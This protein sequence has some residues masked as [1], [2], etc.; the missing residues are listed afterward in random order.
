MHRGRAFAATICLI[1]AV[2]LFGCGDPVQE[3]MQTA[4]ATASAT[5]EPTP[6]VT[7]ELPMPVETVELYGQKFPI[8]LDTLI[9]TE[10]VSDLAPLFDTLMRFPACCSVEIPI[11]YDPSAAEE[12]LAAFYEEWNALKT[13][14]PDI[15]FSEA[16]LIGGEPAETLT[17]YAL[18]A[19]ADLNGEIRAVVSLCPALETLDLSGT[20]ASDEAVAAACQEA[21]GVRILWT[22]AVYGASASDTETLSFSGEQDPETLM[23]YLA[24]FPALK[25]VDLSET[26]LSEEQLNAIGDRFTSVAFHRTVLLNGTTRDS[27]TETLELSRARIDSYEDFSDAIGRFPKLKRLELYECSLSNEQLAAIRD[28]YPGVKVVWTVYVGGW[29]VK[30]DAIAFSTKQL[31][32]NTNRL[33]SDQAQA[34]C[35]CTDLMALDLGH[36]DLTDIEWIRPLTNLQVLI[37]SDNQRLTDISPL[38]DLKRLKYAELFFTAISDISPLADHKDLLDVNLCFTKVTDVSPL[39][40]CGKLERILIGCATAEY[41]EKESISALQNAFPNAQI[42][43]EVLNSTSAGWR[44]HPRYDAYIEMFDTNKPVAPFLP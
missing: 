3:P 20:A 33:K 22:D 27:F 5:A 19:S 38:A 12:G 37:L 26:T 29:R 25:E 10:P 1:T 4:E 15:T 43:I 24:C 16:I 30:T 21:P 42:D 34:L 13:R 7:E 39:L 6:I 44:T 41:V 23:R 18:P 32:N 36:N 9:I 31:K 2:F 17:A 14:Y 11:C 8:D 28:R 40:S 35:Y